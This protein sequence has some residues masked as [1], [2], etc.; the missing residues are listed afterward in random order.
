MAPKPESFVDIDGYRFP[1]NLNNPWAISKVLL[2]KKGKLS[3]KDIRESK[4][5]IKLSA[6]IKVS[7]QVK[8]EQ[9]ESK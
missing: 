7:S 1:K 3:L 4:K 6:Q 9:S 8:F 5:S 2:Q